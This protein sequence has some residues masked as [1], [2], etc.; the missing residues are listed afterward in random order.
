MWKQFIVNWNG[1]NLFLSSAW[2]N[3]DSLELH[4][5]AFGALGY[6]GIF[7]EKWFQIK[8]KPRQQLGQP[9][10]SIAW[11]ELFAIVVDCHI[12]GKFDETMV[13]ILSKETLFNLSNF[14]VKGCFVYGQYACCVFVGMECSQRSPSTP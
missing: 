3:S 10:I 1:A 14:R 4:T 7:G 8:R 2:R 6:G 12:C 13:N 5:D 11:Q 9:E